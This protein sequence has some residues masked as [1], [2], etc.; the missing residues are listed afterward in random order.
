MRARSIKPDALRGQ[1]I[2][3]SNFGVIGGLFA[4]M[5]VIPPQVAIVGAGRAF[6]RAALEN[7]EL[8]EKTILPLSITFDH[9]AL[10]GAE[11]C[12][13]LEAL[14]HDLEKPN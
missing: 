7:G 6:P 5:V 10:T 4:E 12:L 14:R 3:L 13:F 8:T 11:T 1:T 9:R 2:T